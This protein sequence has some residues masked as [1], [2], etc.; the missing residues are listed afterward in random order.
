MEI[1]TVSLFG[2]RELD[3]SIDIESKLDK[4]LHDL[5]A[6]KNILIF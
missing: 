1:Y 2:H 3:L 4:L 5:F 6:K